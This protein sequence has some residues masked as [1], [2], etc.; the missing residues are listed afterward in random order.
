V[1]DVGYAGFDPIFWLHHANVDRLGVMWQA[2]YPSATM[3][4]AREGGGTWTLVSGQT[5]T[6]QTP[7]LPFHRSDGS[8]P[9]TTETARYAKDFGYSYPDVKD[10][11]M[12]ATDLRSSVTARVNTLYN[13]RGTSA[14]RRGR[15][16]V[17]KDPLKPAREWTIEISAPNNALQGESYAVMLFL[18]SKPSDPFQWV[19][20]SIGS[21]FVLAQ[22]MDT[23]LLKEPVPSKTEVVITSFLQDRGVDTRNVKQTKRFLD[24]NLMWGV[25]K[26]DGTV[27]EN[28]KFKGLKL[29]V[30]DDLVKLPE[31]ITELPVYFDKTEHPDVTPLTPVNPAA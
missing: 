28:K 1:T 5:I 30:E 25:Q 22:P 16:G 3:S 18:T 24:N 6:A 4:S 11:T 12:S 14:K 13:L 26:A 29:L 7:L 10:W 31:S 20:Q 19:P 8:T 21:M 15:R 23:S 2:I 17:P 27:V 9:W